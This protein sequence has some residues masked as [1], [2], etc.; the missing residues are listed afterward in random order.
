[1]YNKIRKV[2][3]ADRVLVTQKSKD[4]AVVNETKNVITDNQ[5]MQ[6]LITI[7][8]LNKWLKVK[9]ENW[10][11]LYQSN[12]VSISVFEDTDSEKP[13]IMVDATNTDEDGWNVVRGKNVFSITIDY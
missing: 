12:N 7:N 11:S 10:Y 8:D 1:M 2:L 13:S 9:K 3:K 4:A 5:A 6:V